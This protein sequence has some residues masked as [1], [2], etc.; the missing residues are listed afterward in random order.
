MLFGIML[1]CAGIMTIILFGIKQF[2][3]GSQL[4]SVNQVANVSHLLARQ[5][6]S[7]FSML[8]VNNAKTEQLV[9][10]LDNFVKEEFVLDAAVYARN[11]EL[12]AKSTNSSLKAAV[13]WDWINR[14]KK[15]RI[16]NKLSNRFI[17]QTA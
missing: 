5:Q 15:T 2:K 6:A 13:Y 16:H 4:S 14:K 8:L 3:I 12:L 9:E 1:L 10:N 7:L 11:G 17:L